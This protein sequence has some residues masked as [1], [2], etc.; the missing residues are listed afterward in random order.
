LILNVKINEIQE[1]KKR[2]KELAKEKRA[3]RIVVVEA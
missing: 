3:T 1:S 2:K